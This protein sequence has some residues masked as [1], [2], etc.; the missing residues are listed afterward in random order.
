L[1]QRQQLYPS[2]AGVV[3][4]PSSP[5]TEPKIVGSIPAS[6]YIPRRDSISRP[7]A[8]QAEAIPVDRAARDVY[9][10]LNNSIIFFETLFVLLLGVF[11]LKK[12]QNRFFNCIQNLRILRI[13]LPLRTYLHIYFVFPYLV[14]IQDQIIGKQSK[15]KSWPL[16][17]PKQS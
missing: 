13:P 2:P 7:I 9:K 11:K 15:G 4:W 5:P 14:F 12:C 16:Q 3:Q 8:S 17:S 1:I 10:T 6:V